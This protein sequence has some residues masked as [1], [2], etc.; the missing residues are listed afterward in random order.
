MGKKYVDPKRQKSKDK[1]KPMKLP[2]VFVREALEGESSI[3]QLGFYDKLK[4]L[5]A[6]LDTKSGRAARREA[7]KQRKQQDLRSSLQITSSTFLKEKVYEKLKSENNPDGEKTIDVQL[8]AKFEPVKSTLIA[9]ADYNMDIRE[10]P[11]N[12]NYL[13]YTEDIPIRLVVKKKDSNSI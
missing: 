12:R 6:N 13:K 9:N 7:L 4:R 1:S 3:F 5:I 10:R 2:Y 11:I 8:D